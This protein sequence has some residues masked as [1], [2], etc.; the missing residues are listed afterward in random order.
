VD[1]RDD[2]QFQLWSVPVDGTPVSAG[3]PDRARSTQLA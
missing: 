1:V 2:E 3:V